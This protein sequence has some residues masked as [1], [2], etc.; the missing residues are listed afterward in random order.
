MCGALWGFSIIA[1]TLFLI[2]FDAKSCWG[3]HKPYC[4]M[5]IYL[6][7]SLHVQ[8]TTRCLFPVAEHNWEKIGMD[9]FPWFPKK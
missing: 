9:K 1:E 8:I 6:L 5:L 3:A 7:L 2:Y 4:R